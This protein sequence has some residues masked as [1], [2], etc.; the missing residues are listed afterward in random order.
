MIICEIILHFLVMVQNPSDFVCGVECITKFTKIKVDK[1]DELLARI[2]DV[3]A[4]IKKREY[5]LKEQQAI[6]THGMQN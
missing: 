3:A 4:R 1:R 6:F 5:Q 2:L